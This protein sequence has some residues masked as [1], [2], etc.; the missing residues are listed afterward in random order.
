MTT[1]V[2]KLLPAINRRFHPPTIRLS[3]KIRSRRPLRRHVFRELLC[4]RL[5]GEHRVMSGNSEIRFAVITRNPI[6]MAR[7]NCLSG[8]IIAGKC[9]SQPV[10]MDLEM[11]EQIQA[12]RV[13][14]LC[15]NFRASELDF[16]GGV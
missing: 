12:A 13:N 14:A 11:A 6:L 5:H 4:H 10:S 3:N 9:V 7:I 8:V 16:G 1:G 15:A 2:F